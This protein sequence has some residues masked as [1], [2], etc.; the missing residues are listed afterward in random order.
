MLKDNLGG[1]WKMKALR[2]GNFYDAEVPGSVVQT[3]LDKGTIE[4]PY[5]RD[6]EEKVL[7]FLREDYELTR[8]LQIAGEHLRED[9]VDLVFYGIDTIADIY[10]NGALLSSVDDMHRTYR[11][12]IKGLVRPGANELK[13]ILHSPLNFI[14][15]CEL[16]KENPVKYSANGAMKGSQYIRKA[17]SMFG[18]D[19][20][21]KLPD[22]G[23][24]RNVELQSYSKSRIVD[25]V[26][27]QVHS[28]GN[29]TLYLDPILKI[30]D[31]IPIDVEVIFGN[32]Q[33]IRTMIRMP[34]AGK[35]MT[36]I[37]ENTIEIPVTRPEL[38][39][40]HGMGEQNLYDLTVKV[41]KAGKLFDKKHMRI[42]LRTMEF[43]RE[44][45]QYGEEFA[46]VVNGVKMFAMG[47]NYIPEDSIYS[48][49]TRERQEM[50]IKAAHDAN[51]NC[52]RV[53]GGGYYPS[54]D[55]YDLCD[56]Y[57]IVVWQDLMFGCNIYE[58]DEHFE[59]NII[60]ET[61]D[62][63]RR[64][65]H[66][67]CLGLWCGNNE[68]ETA[69]ENWDGFKDESRALK[70]DY[71]KIFE[72]LLPKAVSKMDD[73]T[74]YWPSSP[75]SGGAFDNPEDENRGDSHYWGVWHGNEPFTEYQNHYFRFVSEFGFQSY[76]GIKTVK[77]F[78]EPA[79]R[80]VYS[81]IFEKHQKDS[82]ANGKIMSYM[83]DNFLYPRDF[84]SVLY[85][86]QL[87]QGVAIKCGVEHFRRNR[88]RCMGSLYWQF[89]DLWPGASWS[90]VDYYGRYKALN[91]MAK[92]FY[93]PISQSLIIEENDEKKAS[94]YSH[95]EI[96][97]ASYVVNDSL[98]SIGVKVRMILRDMEG[99]EIVHYDDS[100]HVLP[101]R[102][103]RIGC[104]DFA[105][106]IERNGKNNV[107]VDAVFEYTDRRVRCE[108]FTFVPYKHLALLKPTIVID[109]EEAE[110]AFNIILES[111]TFV[112]FVM[113]DLKKGDGI[114]DENVI[115]LTANVSRTI[116][117][118]KDQIKGI[119]IP[120]VE[121]LYNILRVDYLQ[122]SYMEDIVTDYIRRSQVNAGDDE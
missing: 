49:I 109:I 89:N 32:M 59:R 78:T 64:I 100:A 111:D 69:W 71:I 35:T 97:V 114:F 40:P 8:M 122:K 53:W 118:G 86:S 11:F 7:D 115:D 87:L 13:V 76:P 104:R 1:T 91:Y 60:A 51:F 23:I 81:Y 61:K 50:L 52:L 6:N 85:V 48:R 65:K 37:G 84:E 34:K 99:K 90:G 80:N 27:D 110:D 113:L 75:S 101:G 116:R 79:D 46:F 102:V 106:Y 77:A 94:K 54:D 21:P 88:G 66:H 24:F 47:A 36:E 119:E 2:S 20:G 107:Y 98:D 44:K 70:A 103:N 12:S 56:E 72:Y 17:H 18:W 10:L 31:N 39:W 29:V 4:D 33:P 82:S 68:I 25:V 105:R 28:D 55:F 42:G 45:D 120:D 73:K 19:F 43:S 74:F 63:V 9:E 93:E 67:A 22:M 57:G 121:T 26:V 15:E 58:L 95:D 96:N 83:A 112:P 92:R 117:L 5:F 14:D 108:T 3:L 38:W 16:N 41:S 62:N 30:V